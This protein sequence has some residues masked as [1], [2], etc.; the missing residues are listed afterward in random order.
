[1]KKEACYRCEGDSGASVFQ[2][3]GYSICELCKT[4]LALHHERTIQRNKAAFEAAASTRK[5][6]EKLTYKEEVE[7]RL[8]IMEK[9]HISKR[10]K[11]MH[12]LDH[13]A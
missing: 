7:R 10:I 2:L 8:V 5:N 4:E 6:P 3:Y 12:I 1:M 11:L 13:L 9:D